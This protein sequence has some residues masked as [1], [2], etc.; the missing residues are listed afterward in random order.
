MPPLP[1]NAV[2]VVLT[3]EQRKQHVQQ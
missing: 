2:A 3:S 1:E